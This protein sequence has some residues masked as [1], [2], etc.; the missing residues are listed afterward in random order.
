MLD[1]VCCLFTHS[2]IDFRTAFLAAAKT[3]AE[4]LRVAIGNEACDLDSIVSSLAAAHHYNTEKDPVAVV[5]PIP[6]EEFCWRQDAVFGFEKVSDDALL[7]HDA[8]AALGLA[9]DCRYRRLL[10]LDQ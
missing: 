1:L 6:R 9:V 8:L 10:P 7:G 5:L 2:L 3:G 4:G